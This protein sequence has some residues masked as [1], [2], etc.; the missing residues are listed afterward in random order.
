MNLLQKMSEINPTNLSNTC[1]KNPN[2]RLRTIHKPNINY[3][4]FTISNH[5]DNFNVLQ[6]PLSKNMFSKGLNSIYA[7]VS[8]ENYTIANGDIN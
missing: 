3:T 5:T 7:N 4:F 8:L 1:I 6:L 2:P